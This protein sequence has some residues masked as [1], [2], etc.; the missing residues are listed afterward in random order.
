MAKESSYLAC[1]VIKLNNHCREVT[2]IQCYISQSV[3]ACTCNHDVSYDYLFFTGVE[4][5]WLKKES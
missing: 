4:A 5:N 3:G 1:L 2:A